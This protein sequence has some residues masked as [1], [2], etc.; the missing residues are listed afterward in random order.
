MK[1]KLLVSLLV[2][3][4]VVATS[5]T[6]FAA[7]KSNSAVSNTTAVAAEKAEAPKADNAAAGKV[8]VAA[9]QE[10][11]A[12]KADKKANDIIINA[13]K[14]AKVPGIYLSKAKNYLKTHPVTDEQAQFIAAKINY[15]SGLVK[16]E[17]VTNLTKLSPASKVAVTNAITEAANEIGLKVSIYNNSR[18]QKVLAILDAQGNTLTEVTASDYKLKQL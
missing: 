3:L 5:V 2:S 17:N 8:T 11:D 14:E 7:V 1:K 4:S 16:Q 15:I 12:V 13:L 10:A 9:G 6:A 18:G